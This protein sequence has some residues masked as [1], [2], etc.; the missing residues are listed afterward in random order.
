MFKKSIVSIVL[1][2]SL[3]ACG[4]SSNNEVEMPAPSI[5]SPVDMPNKDMFFKI[6]GHDVV[7]LYDAEKKRHHL[8]TSEAT[9]DRLTISALGYI[10][11]EGNVWS[12]NSEGNFY[13]ESCSVSFESKG[14]EIRAKY[15]GEILAI[16]FK[17]RLYT[18]N[19]THGKE[20]YR[21]GHAILSHENVPQEQFK[22][23]NTTFIPV[24]GDDYFV[25]DVTG[26]DP[27]GIY[28]TNVT[29]SNNGSSQIKISSGNESITGKGSSA[30]ILGK[31][32]ST[33][34][35]LTVIEN[36]AAGHSYI[37]TFF[38]TGKGLNR[39]ELNNSYGFLS[40][41]SLVN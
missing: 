28:P 27:S 33:V 36:S 17:D 7:S 5:W 16:D 37:A 21:S 24:V 31:D 8:L 9:L 29:Y 3:T 30:V 12:I 22:N 35:S 15:C 11:D 40:F 23:N 39:S 26:I 2:A 14:D 41:E 34:V 32:I 13:L 6:N 4:G 20:I 1:V 18:N 38:S 10:N 25:M 19:L